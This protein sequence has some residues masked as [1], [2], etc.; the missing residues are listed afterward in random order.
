[1]VKFCGDAL[2]VLWPTDVSASE[3]MKS[4]AVRVATM[5]ALHLIADCS[6]VPDTSNPNGA[7]KI[8]CG[9]SCGNIHCMMLGDDDR[10]EFIVSGKALQDM[11]EA[12][13][14]AALG[15]VCLSSSAYAL[16]NSV[17]D[18]ISYHSGVCMITEIKTCS[19]GCD[20]CARLNYRFLK[21]EP[22]ANASEHIGGSSAGAGAGKGASVR[23][24]LSIAASSMSSLKSVT[25]SSDQLNPASLTSPGQ[26]LFLSTHAEQDNSGSGSLK[27]S[28]S[29]LPSG[30]SITR[31]KSVTSDD[32]GLSRVPH[33]P[34]SP[35]PESTMKPNSLPPID[36]KG[37]N[38][39]NRSLLSYLSS[40]LSI[41]DAKVAVDDEIGTAEDV[42]VTRKSRN[43]VGLDG[44]QTADV[45][46][47]GIL[48]E[49][50]HNKDALVDPNVSPYDS[51]SVNRAV[52]SNST[53]PAVLESSS[54]F[55]FR[56][57]PDSSMPMPDA[58]LISN[59][60]HS[61]EDENEAQLY[62]FL[63]RYRH[64][65]GAHKTVS[66]LIKKASSV[67]T[68][69]TSS[70]NSA[71]IVEDVY[72]ICRVFVPHPVRV[73][74]ESDTV[75]FLS[76]I[77]VVSTMFVEILGL[78]EDLNEGNFERPQKVLVA[79]LRVLKKFG[80]GLRQFVVDDKGCV[81]IIGYGIPGHSHEDNC[82]RA[83][84]TAL[85]LHRRLQ[86]LKLDCKIGISSNRVYCGLVGSSYRCEFAMMGASVNLAARLMSNCKSVPILVESN[87]YKVVSD[88]FNFTKLPKINAKGY[89]HPISVYSP[90]GRSNEEYFDSEEVSIADSI[91]FVGREAIVKELLDALD[92]AWK[93]S[94]SMRQSDGSY[95]NETSGC[96]SFMIESLPGL[97]KSKC[98]QHIQHQAIARAQGPFNVL[99]ITAPNPRAQSSM[100]YEVVK[101]YLHQLFGLDPALMALHWVMKN[102]ASTETSL[103]RLPTSQRQSADFT[104][105]V[106]EMHYPPQAKSTSSAEQNAGL[107]SYT[108]KVSIE[109]RRAE[110]QLSDS[111]REIERWLT[112]H[113]TP[114]DVFSILRVGSLSLVPRQ[115][116]RPSGKQTGYKII[117]AYGDKEAVLNGTSPQ[118]FKYSCN[119]DGM[120]E[121][122][123]QTV[124]EN[125]EILDVKTLHVLELLPL[126]SKVLP[127]YSQQCYD[128]Y[129]LPSAA[130]L[131]LLDALIIFTLERAFL[132][133]PWLMLLDH[134]HLCDVTSLDILHQLIVISKKNLVF[135]GALDSMQIAGAGDEDS[136][137]LLELR[138]LCKCLE[139]RPLNI[140]E[141]QLLFDAIIDKSV[142]DVKP[143]SVNFD[144]CILEISSRSE[145]NAFVAVTLIFRLKESILA[146][147]FTD[148]ASL[149]FVA[150]EASITSFDSLS[151]SNQVILKLASI[152]GLT[153]RGTE[154]SKLMTAIGVSSS[155]VNL[156]TGLQELVQIGFLA[157]VPDE[158][159]VDAVNDAQVPLTDQQYGAYNAEDL[160]VNA[161]VTKALDDATSKQY[162]FTNT[163]VHDNIY[164]LM[165]ENQRKI[166][167]Y[168]MGLILEPQFADHED[169]MIRRIVYHYSHSNNLEKK[170]EF[171]ARAISYSLKN[172]D[173]S[174]VK[175][176]LENVIEATAGKPVEELLRQRK[177][178]NK[179]NRDATSS[180]Q[181][182]HFSYSSAV[183]NYSTA[184]NS[185]VNASV[186]RRWAS[187]RMPSVL[188]APAAWLRYEDLSDS[189]PSGSSSPE[190][191]ACWIAETSVI[192]FRYRSADI[193]PSMIY[194]SSFI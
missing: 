125:Y 25:Q 177:S 11:G 150:G 173:Y 30:L 21:I 120:S 141:T 178:T 88:S 51:L 143:S 91:A 109:R 156:S 132:G 100:K 80:G 152:I 66:R 184:S 72:N 61:S 139:L 105:G 144:D 22:K 79:I 107:D 185:G 117:I 56:A 126:L 108:D 110:S 180:N 92:A 162:R 193:A 63:S 103:E 104:G 42:S 38:Q 78:D 87:V 163:A 74:I 134:V 7:L 112:N 182:Y 130:K 149:D 167:H 18:G 159:A 8:H 76:E 114:E 9:V 113:S 45:L 192:F 83:I 86:A 99:A 53:R 158:D 31:P 116:E 52:G 135:I 23:P 59:N 169:Q 5:C 17:F 60:F 124:L 127:I 46:N 13:S 65:P 174:S 15:E 172:K 170:L 168:Y 39:S 73:A 82:L 84:D 3:A 191:V 160:L 24:K 151:R 171:L 140:A 101:M 34:T 49:S 70:L 138:K 81:A 179:S 28:P 97:G 48:D 43:G 26:N 176:Y 64:G 90:H 111:Y 123:L 10:W 188:S 44:S 128:L 118:P 41:N 187:A 166:A 136:D 16:V 153:F 71:E 122:S 35:K 89:R 181:R 95:S 96:Q 183:N 164:E 37:F 155:G 186:L 133:A 14:A 145:G 68:S 40:M 121:P 69:Q 32:D 75:E 142:R 115:L 6:G 157:V 93:Y 58:Q 33:L 20:R 189:L 194:L 2:I 36:R 106:T 94:T 161:A 154:L 57:T 98:L 146:K 67:M 85:T 119:R 129:V 77:R 50:H 175:S 190:R 12:E 102:E 62:S 137:P 4:T 1:V 19:P 29:A 147:T 27:L 131:E 55:E 165:L 47:S 148:I 54:S